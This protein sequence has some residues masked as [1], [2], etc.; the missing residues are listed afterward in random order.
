MII[1]PLRQPFGLLL[2]FVAGVAGTLALTLLVFTLVMRP[3]AGEFQNMVL[4]LSVTAFISFGVVY[5]AYRLGWVRRTPS[6]KWTLV[7]SY[8]L[9]SLLTFINVWVT[10]RLMF[11]NQ[12]DLTLATILLLFAAGI[13]IA[14]GYVL[15]TAL[16]DSIA[17]LNQGATAIAQGR[18]D[19]RVAVEGNDEVASLAATFNHMAEQL[20]EADQRQREARQLRRN[21]IAWVGHDLRTPLAA[22][23]AR[24]EALDD[25]VIDD[26]ATG[27]R[28][29]S[30]VR[31]DIDALSLLI[32]DLFEMAQIDAGGLVLDRRPNSLTDLLSDT[33]ERFSS[34]ARAKQITLAGRVA[35]DVDP[36][37][38]DARLLERV[39]NNLFDNALRHTPPGGTITVHARRRDQRVHITVQDTGSGLA[40]EDAPYV[41]EQFYRGE[42]ARS[43]ATGGSGLGLAIAKSIV[44]AHGGQVWAQNSREGGAVFGVTLPR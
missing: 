27:Q 42:K 41:F 12:H 4:F 16:T 18:L 2:R 36:L 3:P 8:G 17:A 24:I 38:F 7:L 19:A 6:L 32:D 39:F 14:L 28:Y 34:A 35:P 10:A 22:M 20:E 1:R 43:R 33:I 21:L 23:R 13:A 37:I 44:E 31:K 30:A 15:A 11:L 26:P 25:D 5:L 9:A 40:A 29:I